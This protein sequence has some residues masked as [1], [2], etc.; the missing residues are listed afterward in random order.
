MTDRRIFTGTI[1]AAGGG[2]AP[3]WRNGMAIN[4]VKQLL[5]TA[6]AQFMSIMRTTGASGSGDARRIDSYSGWAWDE[7]NL[8]M[9]VHG[10][11]HGDYGG[12]EVYRL[13]VGSTVQ[14]VA[15][16]FPTP[17][18]QAPLTTNGAQYYQ[19][20]DSGQNTLDAS[21]RKARLVAH[22]RLA[23]MDTGTEQARSVW[24][25]LGVSA[26]WRQQLRGLP[27]VGLVHLQVD[28]P[29]Q[30]REHCRDRGEGA[31]PR[32]ERGVGRRRRRFQEVAPLSPDCIYDRR[33]AIWCVL[34]RS[35]HQPE[36]RH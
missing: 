30:H 20:F 14:Y 16:D 29:R 8:R 11:G 27:S 28:D 13:D 17:A 32:H 25:V 9:F 5:P 19:D 36:R 35:G 12:N 33:R 26:E 23:G 10:G 3:A 24:L 15:L 21:W 22:L 18:A 7:P 2:T 6:Q 31:S 34:R 4:Q 1:L